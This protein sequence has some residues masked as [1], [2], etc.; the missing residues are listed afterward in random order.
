MIDGR[1]G[2]GHDMTF[3][4]IDGLG[5]AGCLTAV[6]RLWVFRGL[7]WETVVLVEALRLGL[8]GVGVGRKLDAWI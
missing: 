7:E 5:R 3:L 1:G 8:D 4:M 2:N 6:L